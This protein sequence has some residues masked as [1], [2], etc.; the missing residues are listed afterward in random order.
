MNQENELRNELIKLL[1]DLI[2]ELRDQ[3]AF[4]ETRLRAIK[5]LDSLVLEEYNENLIKLLD[6]SSAAIQYHRE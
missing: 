1:P 3:L 2:D 5:L 4:A 6:P